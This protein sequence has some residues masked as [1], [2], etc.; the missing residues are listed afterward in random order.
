MDLHKGAAFVLLVTY[1]AVVTLGSQY[2]IDLP[3]FLDDVW[4]SGALP[5][6]RGS[7]SG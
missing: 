1:W 7:L 5:A 4:G 6:L 3:G 2:S